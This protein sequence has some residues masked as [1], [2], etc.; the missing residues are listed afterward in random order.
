MIDREQALVL[1]KS[2]FGRYNKIRNDDARKLQELKDG[3]L[4]ELFVL[5]RVLEELR[6]RGF[7]IRL[8]G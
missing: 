3:K 2:V 1:I 4:Y 7:L 5:S 6:G 8:D